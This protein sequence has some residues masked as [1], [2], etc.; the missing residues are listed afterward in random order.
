MDATLMEMVGTVAIPATTEP[1]VASE[2]CVLGGDPK[3]ITWLSDL[4]RE[5]FW[6]KIEPPMAK[7]ELRYA[8]LTKNSVDGPIMDELGGVKETTLAEIY[9]LMKRQPNG[10]QGVLL[11]NGWANI[12]YVPDANGTLRA[13]LVYCNSVGWGLLAHSVGS[14]FRWHGEYR[15]FSRNS[16]AS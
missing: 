16:S 7:T 4:F 1:F 14:L 6:G 12:F 9:A 5:W 3:K 10:E 8:K 11:T 15:V 2:H 13:V